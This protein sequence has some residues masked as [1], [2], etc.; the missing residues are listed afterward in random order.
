[1]MISRQAVMRMAQRL[2]MMCITLV[3]FEVLF[4]LLIVLVNNCF[5]VIVLGS[6]ERQ[7][8]G[9]EPCVAGIE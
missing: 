9:L 2:V 4:I 6:G 5:S 3:V 7:L 8:H 1:M